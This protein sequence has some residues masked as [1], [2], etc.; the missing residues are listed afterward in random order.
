MAL[1]KKKI[2]ASTLMETMVATV[3]IVVIFMLSSLILN[4]LFASQIRGNLQPANT[5][6]DKMEYLFSN[7]K[8]TFPYHETWKGWEISIENQTEGSTVITARQGTGN[9]SRI[10]TRT[11]NVN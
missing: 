6:L 7:R 3:L 5:H 4:N 11:V 10:L 2:K 8:L 1:L 9:E